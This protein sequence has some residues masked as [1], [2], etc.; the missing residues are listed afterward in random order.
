M[1]VDRGNWTTVNELTLLLFNDCVDPYGNEYPTIFLSVLSV[2]LMCWLAMVIVRVL[3]SRT[4][5]A[6]AFNSVSNGRTS[7]EYFSG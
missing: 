3:C 6:D 2:S 5:T 1:V 4:Y 7:N